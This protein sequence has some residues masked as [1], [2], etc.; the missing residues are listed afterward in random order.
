MTD[1]AAVAAPAPPH[2]VLLLCVT[3]NAPSSAR[4]VVNIRRLCE[5]HLHGRYELEVVDVAQHPAV[6]RREQI[7]AAPTLIKKLPLPLR[8][9]IGDLSQ[10]DLILSGFDLP[11]R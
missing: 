6:A 5:Q 9:Y 7:V 1:D 4:A 11:L 3:G 2:F 8:R 10:T